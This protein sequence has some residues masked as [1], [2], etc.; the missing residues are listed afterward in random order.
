MLVCG[1]SGGSAVCAGRG[2]G[3]NVEN[4]MRLKQQGANIVHWHP[5]GIVGSNYHQWSPDREATTHR[6]QD[7]LSDNTDREK[8]PPWANPGPGDSWGM[9]G[10][11]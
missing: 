7:N 11:R 8:I 9:A 5:T 6:I 2:E 1:R 4:V 3:V 10:R